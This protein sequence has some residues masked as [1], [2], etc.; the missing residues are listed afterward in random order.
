M[1]FRLADKLRLK[2]FKGTELEG[3]K[4]DAWDAD[5]KHGRGMISCKD[6]T[7]IEGDMIDGAHHGVVTFTMC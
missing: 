7:I 3:M 2:N 6:G 4:E 1:I 5:K